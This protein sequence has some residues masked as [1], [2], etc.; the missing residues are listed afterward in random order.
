MRIGELFWECRLTC[1]H[2]GLGLGARLIYLV[3]SSFGVLL[4]LSFFFFFWLVVVVTF[5]PACEDYAGRFDESF[6]RLRFSFFFFFFLK[7]NSARQHQ[8]H[9]FKPRINR[10][11]LSELRR[12]WT[13]VPWQVACELVS[14]MGFHTV[15][16]QHSQP[17]PTWLG[18]GCIHVQLYNWGLSLAKTEVTWGWNGY[19]NES[20]HRII[21]SW[22][23]KFSRSYC[24]GSNPRSSD[25]ESGATPLSYIRSLTKSVSV[26]TMAAQV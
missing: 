13:S 24:R 15:P 19:W 2:C 10:R 3:T 18:H 11:L 14:L 1:P 4:S 16:G 21:W 26:N 9:S 6:P 25:H 8:F 22:R 7:R 23:R 12:L 5:I 20:Q 17:T